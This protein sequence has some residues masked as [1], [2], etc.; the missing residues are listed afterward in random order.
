MTIGEMASCILFLFIGAL[1]IYIGLS[2]IGHLKDSNYMILLGSTGIII[3][4]LIS[5]V[6][7][8]KLFNI[9]LKY[10]R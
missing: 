7:K 9:E 3:V 1:G 2:S 10:E 4:I 6:D 5:I 8:K